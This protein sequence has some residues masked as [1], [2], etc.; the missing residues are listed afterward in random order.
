[1]KLSYIVLL[2]LAAIYIHVILMSN[3]VINNV[4][5][6][7]RMVHDVNGILQIINRS[8]IARWSRYVRLVGVTQYR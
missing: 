1:M 8:E 3:A 7:K 6:D 5:G 2:C 4:C